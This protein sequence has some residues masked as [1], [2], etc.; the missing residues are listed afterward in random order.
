MSRK[1]VF[2]YDIDVPEVVQEKAEAAFSMIRKYDERTK[3]KE[4]E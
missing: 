2:L 1:N 3:K 4:K